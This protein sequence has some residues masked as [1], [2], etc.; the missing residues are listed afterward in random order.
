M[1]AAY[2]FIGPENLLSEV[3]EVNLRYS[4]L[5]LAAIWYAFSSEG[6]SHDLM[7]KTYS[8]DLDVWFGQH[9]GRC[10]CYELVYPFDVFVCAGR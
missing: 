4:N 7:A 6:T 5:P 3:G 10:V 8:Y 9:N 1:R 2:K